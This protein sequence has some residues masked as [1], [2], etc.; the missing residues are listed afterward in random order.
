MALAVAVQE[1]EGPLAIL[2]ELVERQKLPVTEISVAAVTAQ[3]LERLQTL[4]EP[5]AERMSEFLQLGA[6][7]LYI[8]SLALL[9]RTAAVEQA[10]ELATLNLELDEYRRYQQAARA[11]G[12]LSH[13]GSWPR[14]ATTRLPTHELPLPTI[15]TDELAAAFTRAIRTHEPAGPKGVIAQQLT[16][17]EVVKRL[18]QRLHKGAFE[19][20]DLLDAASDRLEIIVTFL[21]LLELIKGGELHVTQAAQYAPLIVEPAVAPD[22]AGCTSEPSEATHA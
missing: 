20:Q 16:Q 14:T 9:P 13:H 5:N 6:R 18:R 8:K 21:A 10:E 4:G 19:L 17:A 12:R 22:I 7:L 1:F 3:Y 15:T 11:L 2:L